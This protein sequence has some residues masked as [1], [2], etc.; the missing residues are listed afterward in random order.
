MKNITHTLNR[1][2]TWI[3][4]K[5][6][7]VTFFW[8][9]PDSTV[10]FFTTHHICLHSSHTNTLHQF[11]YKTYYSFNFQV[12]SKLNSCSQSKNT[13]VHKFSQTQRFLSK[14]YITYFWKCQVTIHTHRRARTR[15]FINVLADR[16]WLHLLSNHTDK[17]NQFFYKIY[18]TFHFQILSIHPSCSKS[19]T[20]PVDHIATDPTHPV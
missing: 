12:F 17:L 10:T 14:R 16:V 11:F 13:P 15:V 3:S 2:K 19:K 8:Q 4:Q 1:E 6:M 20:T 5:W 9:E 18:Y 7:T